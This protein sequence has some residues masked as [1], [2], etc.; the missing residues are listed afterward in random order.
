M[1]TNP[2]EYQARA[3]YLNWVLEAFLA[4][5][6]HDEAL[7]KTSRMVRQ[8]VEAGDPVAAD[9]DNALFIWIMRWWNPYRI[10]Q[11]AS[12]RYRILGEVRD[13]LRL[14]QELAQL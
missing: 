5:D 3:R 9:I 13:E 12:D 4:A 6:T 11:T 14:A 10:P 2:D 7:P 1:T 8:R